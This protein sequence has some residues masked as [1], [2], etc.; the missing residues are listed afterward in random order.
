MR[1]RQQPMSVLARMLSGPYASGTTVIDKTGLNGKY[2]FTLYYAV[3][4]ST[5]TEPTDAPS[6]FDAVQD[7]LGLKSS[8]R[9]K[10]LS[11]WLLWIAWKSRRQ[12]IERAATSRTTSNKP[13]AS[14]LGVAQGIS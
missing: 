9:R 6:L 13:A 11:I 3:P 1:G 7:Q 8:S 12:R 14:A 2:D 10:S 5:S 4:S